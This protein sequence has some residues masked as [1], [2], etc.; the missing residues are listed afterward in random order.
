MSNLYK[1][2]FVVNSNTVKRV[3]NSNSL[4]SEKLK[5]H[6]RGGGLRFQQFHEDAPLDA[7]GSSEDDFVNGISAEVVEV[8]PEVSVQQILEDANKEA[9]EILLNARREAEQIRSAAAEEAD[10]IRKEAHKNGYE[11]GLLEKEQALADKETSISQIILEKEEE[12]KADYL[13]KMSHMESD[14][15]DAVISVFQHVFEVEFENKRE[16][17]FSL[18]KNTLLNIEPGKSFRIRINEENHEFL[19]EHLESIRQRIGKDIG[20]EIINDASLKM[21]DCLIETD[22]GVFDC[23]IDREMDNLVKDIKA[24]CGS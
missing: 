9:E 3:I 12:L 5:E 22:F 14:I 11:E 6:E 16:I 1:Q 23:G 15:V 10:G 24:L 13:D 4:V 19:E 7:E 17:L 21:T 18:V 8:E 2:S 20:I